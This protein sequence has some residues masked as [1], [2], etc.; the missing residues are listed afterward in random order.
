[1]WVCK[2]RTIQINM[3]KERSK[4]QQKKQSKKA[5]QNQKNIKDKKHVKTTENALQNQKKYRF[6]QLRKEA[7]IDHRNSDLWFSVFFYF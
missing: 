7:S 2:T 5:M 4:V 1:M 6:E 3:L